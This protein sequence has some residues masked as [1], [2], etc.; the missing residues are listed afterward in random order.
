MFYPT[1]L[2]GCQGIVF[3]HDVLVGGCRYATS[4]CDL[5]LTFDIA[6]VTVTYK[7]LSRL[8][9]GNCKV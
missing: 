1:A 7:I 2:K 4:W 5:D 3:T 9:L 6:V 8:Y